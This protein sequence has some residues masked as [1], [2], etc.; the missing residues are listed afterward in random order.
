MKHLLLSLV[1]LFTVSFAFPINNVMENKIFE[2]YNIENIETNVFGTCVYSITMT[3]TNTDTGKT[4][5]TTRTYTTSASSLAE[6]Q[7][8]ASAH[9]KRLNAMK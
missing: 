8:I 5:T 7:S 4:Y 9:A 2:S 1:F 6:C 3:A